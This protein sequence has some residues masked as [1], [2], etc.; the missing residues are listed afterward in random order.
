LTSN[1]L[2]E[3]GKGK[4]WDLVVSSN[5]IKRV[6]NRLLQ[7][8]KRNIQEIEEIALWYRDNFFIEPTEENIIKAFKLEK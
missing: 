4:I 7:Y 5:E 6:Y 3:V 2:I 1:P 8:K